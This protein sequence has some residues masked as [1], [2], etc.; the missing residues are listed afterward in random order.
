MAPENKNFGPFQKLNRALNK[1]IQNR[2]E[3]ID[4]SSE[5]F[6]HSVMSD[7]SEEIEN[8]RSLD[9]PE[10]W[11]KI[12]ESRDNAKLRVEIFNRLMAMGGK[13]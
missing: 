1:A 12:Y 7:L 6:I 4:P 10:L 13:N 5:V 8:I 3:S 9:K 2:E 11:K